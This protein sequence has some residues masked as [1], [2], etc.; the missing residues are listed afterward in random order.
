MIQIEGKDRG[1]RRDDTCDHGLSRSWKVKVRE[2]K[3]KKCLGG[4]EKNSKKVRRQHRRRSDKKKEKK[5]NTYEYRSLFASTAKQFAPPPFT[6]LLELQI[7]FHGISNYCVKKRKKMVS[8][9]KCAGEHSYYSYYDTAT[10]CCSC[11][12][13]INGREVCSRQGQK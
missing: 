3:K 6:T 11:C 13:V 9:S 4:R 12:Y 5:E 1:G 8:R 2:N 7:V 10:H